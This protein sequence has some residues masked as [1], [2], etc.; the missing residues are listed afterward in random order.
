MKTKTICCL[1][2]MAYQF[3]METDLQGGGERYLQDFVTLLKQLGYNVRLYQFSYVKK[4]KSFRGHKINGLGNVQGNDYNKCLRE[5][6]REFKKLSQDAD[7]IFL[8]SMNLAQFKFDKPTLT[9][10]HGI[11][12]DNRFEDIDGARKL[13]MMMGEWINNVDCTISVDTNTIHIMQLLHPIQAKKM[14]FVPNYVD[15]DIFKPSEK[16]YYDKKLKVLFARRIAPERGYVEMAKACKIL[17]DTLGEDN[18]EFTFCGSGHKHEVDA[19]HSIIDG[20]NNVKHISLQHNEMYKAY[21]GMYISVV[22]TTKSEG[23]SLSCLESLATG[24]VPIVTTIGGLTDIVTHQHNGLMIAP[25]DINEIVNSIMYLYENRDELKTMS[26]RC[27]DMSNSFSKEL[28]NDR[29]EYVID[30]LYGT[31]ER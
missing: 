4:S 2:E 10:S 20:M 19:L 24:T 1:A 17:T 16:D 5:G 27:I 12:F 7:G 3:D 28:W 29:I 15:L 31:N 18:I 30:R 26:D 11:F 25:K 8:L 14:V 9:V 13:S 22:P 6:V 23:S 21:E